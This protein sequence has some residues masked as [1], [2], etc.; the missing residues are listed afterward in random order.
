M[1]V[2]ADT[3]CAHQYI[4]DAVMAIWRQPPGRDATVIRRALE[5]TM[6][7]FQVVATLNARAALQ[8][9]LRLGA[10]L[11]TGPASL[12]NL[13]SDTN[14]DYTALGDSVSKGFRLEAARTVHCDIL[15]GEGTYQRLEETFARTRLRR[16]HGRVEGLCR[17]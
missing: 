4:G 9:S 10:G 8:S 17:S 13:G 12:G 16:A 11:N 3:A 15:L 14:A 5:S 6:E 1:Q 2:C 7:L